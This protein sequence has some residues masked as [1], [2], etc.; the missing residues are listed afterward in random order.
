M[1]PRSWLFWGGCSTKTVSKIVDANGATAGS[2]YKHVVDP[3]SLIRVQPPIK[4]IH[5]QTVTPYALLI[6]FGLAVMVT[7]VAFMGGI[8]RNNVNKS[9]DGKR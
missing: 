7:F 5:I 3:F 1:A 9:N 4:Q 8:A 6:F 2:E